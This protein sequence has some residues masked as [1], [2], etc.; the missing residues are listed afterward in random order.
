MP[1]DNGLFRILTK[2]RFASTPAGDLTTLYDQAILATPETIW[3][4]RTEHARVLLVA[5]ML[6]LACGKG[7]AAGPVKR[8]KVGKQEREFAVSDNSTD[9]LEMTSYGK[10]FLRLRRALTTTPFFTC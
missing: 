4:D 2:G 5:H 9:A 7:D 1:L 3:M 10:E 6:Q 8:Q